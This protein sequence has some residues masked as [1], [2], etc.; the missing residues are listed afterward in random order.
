MKIVFTSKQKR[1]LNQSLSYNY[2][3]PSRYIHV[4]IHPCSHTHACMHTC[5]DERMREWLHACLDSWMAAYMHTQG[6]NQKSSQSFNSK[7]SIKKINSDPLCTSNHICNDPSMQPSMHI[8]MHA[9]IHTCTNPCKYAYKCMY[10]CMD[11]G[12]CEYTYWPE[13]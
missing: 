5:M 6:L 3:P 13:S 8:T 2:I 9:V 10:V 4:H 12:V 1:I 11:G 7:F